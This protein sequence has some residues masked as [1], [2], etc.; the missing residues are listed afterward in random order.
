VVRPIGPRSS[1]HGGKNATK[2][3]PG[4]S[5][6]KQIEGSDASRNTLKQVLTALDDTVAKGAFAPVADACD[7]CDYLAICGPHREQRAA[8]KKGDSRLAAFY[9]MREIQ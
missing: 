2:R 9:K 8:R 3:R 5:N 4:W 7:Y 1:S 6:G